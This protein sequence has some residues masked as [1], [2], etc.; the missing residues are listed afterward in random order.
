MIR[1]RRA[2][3]EV[4]T[5]QDFEEL[6]KEKIEKEEWNYRVVRSPNGNIKKLVGLCIFHNEKTPSLTL[7]MES[8][9][10]RCYGCGACGSVTDTHIRL[11]KAWNREKGDVHI[12]SN[13]L[14]LL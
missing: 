6:R 12:P 9:Q 4:C 1:S 11:Y 7:M 5:L 14:S 2:L 3:K 13:Q 10:Y 8:G